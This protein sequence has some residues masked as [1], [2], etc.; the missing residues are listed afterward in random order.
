MKLMRGG[1]RGRGDMP[2]IKQFEKGARRKV[3]A[4]E[5]GGSRLHRL[6]DP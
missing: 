5:L 3:M 1:F 2:I 6:S 4:E